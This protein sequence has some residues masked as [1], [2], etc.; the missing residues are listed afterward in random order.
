MSP[1]LEDNEVIPVVFAEEPT[2]EKFGKIL[3]NLPDDARFQLHRIGQFDK[4]SELFDKF[5][6][7]FPDEVPAMPLPHPDRCHKSFDIKVKSPLPRRL[8]R[9]RWSANDITFLV[10]E[11]QKMERLGMISRCSS[12][13]A[14]PC[15]VAKQK[16]RRLRFVVDF[17]GVNSVTAIPHVAMPDP[18]FF[19]DARHT[20]NVLEVYGAEC[21]APYRAPPLPLRTLTYPIRYTLPCALGRPPALPAPC[22]W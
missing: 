21:E 22:D 4:V 20:T 18:F 2:Y 1:L 7:L 16:N 11:I 12:E 10:F 15:F 19:E 6:V 9:Y 5:K 14:S 3:P 17:R 8:R 13:Y